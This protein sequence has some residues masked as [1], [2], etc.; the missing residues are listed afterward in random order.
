[1]RRET[2]FQCLQSLEEEVHNER[3]IAMPRSARSAALLL[4]QMRPSCRKRVKAST[5]LSM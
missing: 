3:R 2:N 4:M 5:R 1:L